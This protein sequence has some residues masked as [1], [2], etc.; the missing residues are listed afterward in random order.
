MAILIST[1]RYRQDECC[2]LLFNHVNFGKA[3]AGLHITIRYHASITK[4]V[5][6]PIPELDAEQQE[7][8]RQEWIKE[9][10]QKTN[11]FLAENGVIPNKVIAD[12]SRYL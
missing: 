11:S 2:L 10:F 6:T 9:Q 7:A 8:L 1:L 3:V 12:D 4:Q 5:D